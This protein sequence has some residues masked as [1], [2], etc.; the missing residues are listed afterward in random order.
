VFIIRIVVNFS[1]VNMYMYI[2][3]SEKYG[4]G[5]GAG[6][7]IGSLFDADAKTIEFFVNGV[8]QGI[9]FKD[10]QG[11]LYPSIA[12]TPNHSAVRILQE[13]PRNPPAVFASLTAARERERMQVMRRHNV[14]VSDCY[15][16]SFCL[17]CLALKY[18]SFICVCECVR[19]CERPCFREQSL[20][21]RVMC[22]VDGLHRQSAMR[23][24]A[25]SAHAAE[26][27]CR[28]ARYAITLPFYDLHVFEHT[29]AC[30]STL[31]VCR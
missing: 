1:W 24:L 5:Y 20:R 6:D 30:D 15:L 29:H 16:P 2:A 27:L 17:Y 28:L 14:L 23:V 21:A 11:P 22:N 25:V 13:I 18:S 10:V 19:V 4:R 9:A 3:R 7:V 12:A 26:H 8:S 31:P